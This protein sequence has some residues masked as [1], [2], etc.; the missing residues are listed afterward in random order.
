MNSANLNT[1]NSYIVPAEFDID[2][3]N[4]SQIKYRLEKNSD[5]FFGY[6]FVKDFSSGYKSFHI[7][8][9]YL[10]FLLLAL[11]FVVVWWFGVKK[12]LSNF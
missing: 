2:P 9:S 4:Y 3:E 7:M 10:G 6:S 11:L 8:S 5:S 12:P 1:M